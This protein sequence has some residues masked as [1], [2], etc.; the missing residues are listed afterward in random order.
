MTSRVP[1]GQLSNRKGLRIAL[2]L[3][4]ALA[5]GAVAGIAAGYGWGWQAARH[6]PEGGKVMGDAADDILAG[7]VDQETGEWDDDTYDGDG[8]QYD[9]DECERCGGEGFI[10]YA[11]AGPDVWGEDCPSEVNHLVT[12][13]E[14]GGWGHF[15]PEPKEKDRVPA[16]T[17]SSEGGG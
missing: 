10:E 12:C 16:E 9:S 8:H 11:D 6:A 13:P 14:C 3:L 17:E 7:R 1:F 2:A 5:L 4:A 15:A